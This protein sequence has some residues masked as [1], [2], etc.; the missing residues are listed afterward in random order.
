MRVFLLLL[1]LP[2]YGNAQSADKESFLSAWEQNQSNSALVEDFRKISDGNYHIKFKNLPYEGELLLLTYDVESIPYGLEDSNFNTTGYV[3]ID[4]PGAMDELMQKYSRTYYKWAQNNVL[5]YDSKSGS[6]V[7]PEVYSSAYKD[8]TTSIG[9]AI[10]VTIFE[11]W[12]YALIGIILYF[13]WSTVVN[14][15]RTKTAIKHQEEV[16]EK[17]L[18]LSEESIELQK[19]SIDECIKLHENTNKLLLQ[20]SNQIEPKM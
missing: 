15:K 6:W 7:S 3:E 5:Y 16:L 14:N 2:L 8:D 11:Y 10:Y 20:I 17:S 19:K 18:K 4:I 1:L 13:L 12:S 9:D